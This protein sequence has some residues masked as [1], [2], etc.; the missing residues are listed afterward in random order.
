MLQ[1]AP[2]PISVH[3]NLP[4]EFLW[5]VSHCFEVPAECSLL[6]AIGVCRFRKRAWFPCSSALRAKG[7]SGCPV[8]ELSTACNPTKS[9]ESKFGFGK[10][11]FGEKAWL[12]VGVIR[13]TLWVPVARIASRCALQNLC[14]FAPVTG[15]KHD[16]TNDSAAALQSK[17]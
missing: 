15:K 12:D 16:R 7:P 11:K 8:F 1:R 14:I 10:A 3:Q 13:G 9:L 5:T 17:A 6:L 4:T 2:M